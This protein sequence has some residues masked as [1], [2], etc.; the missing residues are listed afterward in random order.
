MNYS[1]DWVLNLA[2]SV[3]TK[4]IPANQIWAGNPARFIK[5]TQNQLIFFVV[6]LKY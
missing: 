1:P 5:T 4:D 3:I 2:C 6:I